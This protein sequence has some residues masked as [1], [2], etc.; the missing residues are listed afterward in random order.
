M[1]LLVLVVKTHKFTVLYGKIYITILDQ[2]QI[3]KKKKHSFHSLS[4]IS[5]VKG[6]SVL[7]VGGH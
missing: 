6:I 7:K 1:N 3:P 5:R 4:L 2:R